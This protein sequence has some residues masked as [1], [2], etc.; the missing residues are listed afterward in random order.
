MNPNSQQE[1]ANKS[2]VKERMD[3]NGST[4]SLKIAKLDTAMA[5][6]D[7][8]QQTRSCGREKRREEI[9]ASKCGWIWEGMEMGLYTYIQIRVWF[10]FVAVESVGGSL[11]GEV[12]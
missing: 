2:K 11:E 9:Y 1:D 6:R 12:T 5:A 4:T 10:C 7:L 8:K 3:H